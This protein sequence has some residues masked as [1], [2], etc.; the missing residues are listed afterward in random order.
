MRLILFGFDKYWGWGL[1]PNLHHER[2]HERKVDIMDL[3]NFKQKHKVAYLT[4]SSGAM[5]SLAS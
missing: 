4:V 3:G 2:H 5:R 1:T